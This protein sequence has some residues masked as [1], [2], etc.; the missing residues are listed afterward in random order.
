MNILVVVAHLDDETFGMGGTLIELSKEHNVKVVSVCKGRN[1]E[2]SPCRIKTFKELGKKY[3][4]KTKILEHWDLTLYK[5]SPA[6][7]ADEIKNEI[8]KFNPEVI[9]TVAE[10]IHTEHKLVNACVKVA[11]RN[12]DVKKL[13]EIFI[14][15]S[16]NINTFTINQVQKINL[17]EKIKN[18]KMYSSEIGNKIPL[19]EYF[20]KFIGLNYNEKPSEVFY[21]VQ[22]KNG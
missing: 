12:T 3:N 10:D 21:V 7:L 15:G 9:Y 4:Y 13:L 2:D 5:F 16:S 17:E 11:V 19:I 8:K 22:D 14:P 6:L 18:C 1:S 20:H